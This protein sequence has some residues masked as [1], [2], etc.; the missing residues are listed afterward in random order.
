M[1]SPSSSSGAVIDGTEYDL[2]QREGLINAV[3]E[4]SYVNGL[5]IVKGHINPNVG[6]YS[7]YNTEDGS[8]EEDV[9]GSCMSW[10]SQAGIEQPNI[11]SIVSRNRAEV[12][13]PS[14]P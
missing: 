9:Y 8:W 5:W 14:L 13:S 11:S 12:L 2:A 7:F 4:V 3:T 1:Y 6:S 10:D